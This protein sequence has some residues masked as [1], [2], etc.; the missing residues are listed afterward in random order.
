MAEHPSTSASHSQQSVPD[1]VELNDLISNRIG[2]KILFATDD[3][4]AV[5]ENLLNPEPA[6]WKE[7]EFTK[8]GKWMD[9]WESRRKRIAGHDWCIIQLGI[10]GLIHGVDVDTSYFTGNY[11]PR[12]SIQAACLGDDIVFPKRTATMGSAASDKDKTEIEKMGVDEWEDIVEVTPLQPGYKDTC[13]NY[14]TVNSTKRWTHLR[15][16][17]YP[18][19]GIARLRV[20][21]EAVPNWS[22]VSPH[23]LINLVAV[24]NGGVC[25]GYSDVH[26]GHARN[27]LTLPRSLTMAD[28]WETA[29]RLDRPAILEADNHGVLKVQGWEWA[30]FRLGHQGCIKRIEIDTNHFKGNYP[31]SCS[32]EGCIMSSANEK[33]CHAY[34]SGKTRGDFSDCMWT[35]IL[36]PSKLSAHN[37]HFYESTVVDVGPVTHVRLIMRPDGGI[38]RMRLWGYIHKI[39]AKM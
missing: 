10:S 26:F 8:Y 25:L 31:D 2:G 27:L 32:I 5:A 20:Y 23:Q 4:F 18:D 39:A 36:P 7:G 29:R 37:Q 13:H 19:G 24:E 15:L 38:S 17:M 9:G 3:W 11:A 1:F 35:V 28:G 34:R 16:N 6:Q 33:R 22:K 21:G 12:I 30:V 14:F